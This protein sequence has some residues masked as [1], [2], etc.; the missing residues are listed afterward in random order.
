MK[1]NKRIA[2][3]A[4]A[5]TIAAV[6]ALSLAMDANATLLTVDTYNAQLVLNSVSDEELSHIKLSK[7]LELATME[8]RVEDEYGYYD[9]VDVPLVLPED[10]SAVWVNDEK[11]D[12]YEGK[13]TEIDLSAYADTSDYTYGKSLTLIV[14]TAKQLDAE[15]NTVY[16]FTIR[17]SDSVLDSYYASLDLTKYTPSQ[18]AAFSV[19]E[20]L[21]KMEVSKYDEDVDFSGITTVWEY[22]REKTTETD[23]DGYTYTRTGDYVYIPHKLGNGE[24]IDLYSRNSVKLI[25][26]S[27]EYPYD[28]VTNGG[29]KV[30][31]LSL[32]RLYKSEYSY[33]LF[34]ADGENAFGSPYV[35]EYSGRQS[36]NNTLSVYNDSKNVHFFSG[37]SEV[38]KE[39]YFRI[40]ADTDDYEQNNIAVNVYKF[41]DFV[42]DD[43]FGAYRQTVGDDFVPITDEILNS[44]K[45]WKSSFEPAKDYEVNDNCFVIAYTKLVENENGEKVDSKQ[46][47]DRDFVYVDL[48]SF[49]LES[50]DFSMKNASGEK[51]VDYNYFYPENQNVFKPDPYIYSFYDDNDNLIKKYRY[52][53]YTAPGKSCYDSVYLKDGY[54]VEDDYIFNIEDFKTWGNEESIV[55]VKIEE[56][57]EYGDDFEYKYTDVTE[58][59]KKGYV[60]NRNNSNMFRFTFEN[61]AERYVSFSL[62]GDSRSDSEEPGG[63]DVDDYDDDDLLLDTAPLKAQEDPYFNIRSAKYTDGE[64]NVK[65]ARCYPVTYYNSYKNLDSLYR[66]GY[67]TVLI[68]DQLTDEQMENLMPVF[69][70]YESSKAMVYILNAPQISGETK[71]NANTKFVDYSVSTHNSRPDIYEDRTKNYKV[72]F[73][74]AVKGGSKLFVNGPEER[75][76]YF[77]DYF[78]DYHDVFLANIG[79][80]DLTGLKAELIDGKNIRLDK[81]WNVGGENNDLLK[82]FF[83]EYGF[84]TNN[85]A[86]IRLVPDGEGEISG[87]LK[88]SADGQEDVYIKL[89]GK[90][91]N[92]KITTSELD[93][94]VKYVPYSNLVATDNM[95]DWVRVRFYQSDGRFPNGVSLNSQTGEI[96]GTPQKSGEYNV[97]VSANFAADNGY[98]AFR[99][100]S[101]DLKLVVDENSNMNVFKASDDHYT[102]KQ[103]IGT[104]TDTDPYDFVM[105]YALDSVQYAHKKAYIEGLDEEVDTEEDDNG[106]EETLLSGVDGVND[107]LF[108]SIGEYE[109]FMD[110]WFNGKK[111]EKDKDYKAV[112]G[113]TEITIMS[114]TLVDNVVDGENTIAA[115]FRVDGD[116]DKELKRTAQNFRVN[117]VSDEFTSDILVK[118]VDGNDKPISNTSVEIHSDVSKASTNGNGYARFP[119]IASGKHTVSAKGAKADFEI[120]NGS[121]IALDGNVISAYDGADYMLTLRLSGS[122]LDPVSVNKIDDINSSE[123][124]DKKTDD[125]SSKNDSS[126]GSG[127][128]GSGSGSGSSGSSESTTGTSTDT[129]GSADGNGSTDSVPAP[130]SSGDTGSP[131]TTV[132]DQTN[133]SSAG[134]IDITTNDNNNNNNGVIYAK[135]DGD[136][137]ESDNTPSSKTGHE[138]NYTMIALSLIAAVAALFYK[139]ED[140]AN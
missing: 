56:R 140:R 101:V 4:T 66:M 40:N 6:N 103:T 126:T 36:S 65:E 107:E 91:G 13:D 69:S 20:I 82:P 12:I 71:V 132:I 41:S 121:V 138:K 80:A 115:E 128:S 85:M 136:S 1:K 90:S 95:Y 31:N 133:S 14:G 25:L 45:G 10:Y 131:A 9:Y 61:G 117:L 127:D 28:N 48:Q 116:R 15:N 84:S 8:K 99:S 39:L 52:F 32:S 16:N 134:S 43:P 120:V 54:Y 23:E 74:K 62:S 111:L 64:G 73:V 130:G 3:A 11:Y 77:N 78:G 89:T 87:T 129:A 38:P 34:T 88:V 106:E 70:S 139:R 114:Q 21:E 44:E 118:L 17:R 92:P 123:Y 5:L 75:E 68:S 24:T 35:E 102:I 30:V 18:T 63:G 29:N 57:G 112:K 33:G 50:I 113:S 109:E 81:Y 79:D 49:M 135:N 60:F 110:F 125:S 67:Q 98:T 94:A 27:G 97:T 2:A 100:S 96:Y 42:K 119:G 47:I 108:I 7:M 46:I 26:G 124:D 86:K 104:N 53:S 51:A 122:E 55:P 58:E 105:T 37:N 59:F 72:S 22:T 93:S 137:S 83:D 76:V 19:D